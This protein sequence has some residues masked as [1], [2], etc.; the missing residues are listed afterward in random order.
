MTFHHTAGH[1]A[2][3]RM[4]FSAFSEPQIRFSFLCS[5]LHYFY[6][7]PFF[8]FLSPQALNEITILNTQ[9]FIYWASNVRIT[10]ETS[11]HE[12]P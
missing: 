9:I 2:P 1:A 4:G 6:T 11:K 8:V 3:P 7:P 5:F 10:E 12:V